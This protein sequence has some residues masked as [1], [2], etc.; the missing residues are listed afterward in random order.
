MDITIPPRNHTSHFINI[1]LRENKKDRCE[2]RGGEISSTAF[3]CDCCNVWKHISCVDKLNHDLPL[4][5]IHPL[6]L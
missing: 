4:E 2:E 6:H 3:T 1:T 5:I